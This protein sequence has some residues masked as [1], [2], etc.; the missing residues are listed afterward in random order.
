ML[1]EDN[2]I[3]LEEDMN[4]VYHSKTYIQ[5]SG[6]STHLYYESLEYVYKLLKEK[7]K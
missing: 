5:L 3:S 7:L 6:Y 2:Q 4:I 1:F